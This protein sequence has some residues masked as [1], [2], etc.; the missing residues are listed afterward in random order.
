M[1]PKLR[2]A[3]ADGE[4]GRISRTCPNTGWSASLATLALVYGA[5]LR[6]WGEDPHHLWF[7]SLVADRLFLTAFPRSIHIAVTFCHSITDHCPAGQ[8][9]GLLIAPAG[10]T[11]CLAPSPWCSGP[12]TWRT[13]PCARRRPGPTVFPSRR[14]VA[15]SDGRRQS[16]QL[17]PC[18]TSEQ[19]VGGGCGPFRLPPRLLLQSPVDVRVP[20][21]R[22]RLAQ[23]AVAGCLRHIE[24]RFSSNPVGRS[25]EETALRV[26]L[27]EV[28]P[29]VRVLTGPDGGLLF[30]RP[31]SIVS[32]LSCSYHPFSRPR[33]A[34]HIGLRAARSPVNIMTL[35][36]LAPASRRPFTLVPRREIEN[37][38]YHLASCRNPVT[39]GAGR[40]RSSTRCRIDAEPRLLSMLWRWIAVFTLVSS[41]SGWSARSPRWRSPSGFRHGASY[42]LFLARSAGCSPALCHLSSA[43][44]QSSH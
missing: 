26:L 1:G 41:W 29:W 24:N 3:S 14:S 8:R 16:S 7:Y 44:A 33:A 36:G 12:W 39:T 43:H 20:T 13:C 17:V 5:N 23:Y 37:I 11:V 30:L 42:L 19:A 32:A 28:S 2:F 15:W 18:A 10:P 38:P 4:K 34:V 27:I 6:S 31:G 35:C 25:T 21:I 9:P 22:L 40:R